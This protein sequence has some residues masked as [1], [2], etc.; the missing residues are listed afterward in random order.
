MQ[1]DDNALAGTTIPRIAP[2]NRDA[3]EVWADHER[4]VHVEIIEELS[5]A[6][7]SY[8]SP[9]AIEFLCFFTSPEYRDVAGDQVNALITELREA[10]EATYF[11]VVAGSWESE[12]GAAC[13]A[14]E[15]ETSQAKKPLLLEAGA[16]T[17]RFCFDH[18]K[19]FKIKEGCDYCDTEAR[20]EGEARLAAMLDGGVEDEP[21]A[22][23]PPATTPEDGIYLP[24]ERGRESVIT[25]SSRT[26]RRSSARTSESKTGNEGTEGEDADVIDLPRCGK[27]GTYV[28][29]ATEESCTVCRNA[30][31]ND[32][33]DEGP[34][35]LGCN[36][37]TP[38]FVVGY[39]GKNYYYCKACY[40]DCG[41]LI[42]EK[43]KTF[44]LC[45]TKTNHMLK[46]GLRVCHTHA[47]RQE[48]A[49]SDTTLRKRGAT[50][51]EVS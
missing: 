16:D 21:E 50:I 51:T 2:N 8:Y 39:A 23:T 6:C 12:D 28:L 15:V 31:K 42:Q 19:A 7:G 49:L 41:K 22:E 38:D 10:Y 46:D 20:M 11:D 18:N 48:N 33:P 24:F 5:I 30:K 13:E 26:H 17:W 44:R 45:Y 14:S 34:T 27:C 47:R 4:R 35:C 3:L 29:R 1:D 9:Q 25:R 37:A 43:D 36:A 40:S 32:E